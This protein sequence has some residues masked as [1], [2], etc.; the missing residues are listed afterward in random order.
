LTKVNDRLLNLPVRLN[1]DDAVVIRGIFADREYST[2]LIQGEIRRVIDL[3]ANCGFALAYLSACFP[4]ASFACIEPDPRN[5]IQLAKNIELNQLPAT[6]FAAGVG[7][8]NGY[9][10]LQINSENPSCNQITEESTQ[11]IAV[12]VLTLDDILAQMNWESVD[13]IK[14]DIEGMEYD[15]VTKSGKM[16][17]KAKYIL[18][19]LHSWIDTKAVTSGLVN[20]GFDIYQVNKEGEQVY[21]AIN[22]ALIQG[23]VEFQ[24]ISSYAKS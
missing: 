21:L 8:T 15:L 11:G 12:A 3:G 22:K 16:L 5:L 23:T 18:F 2:E 17:Q 14:M 20:L 24:N 13:L 1:T 4:H 19:E 7:A 9:F 10:R 6:V